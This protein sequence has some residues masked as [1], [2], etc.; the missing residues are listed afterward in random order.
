VADYRE[1]SQQYAQG[2]FKAV[3]LLNGGASVAIL[4]Q[5][6]ELGDLAQP[7]LVA[8]SF[9]A[10]GITLSALA[11]L[12]AFLS[13]RY[14]DKHEREG[15]SAH[16]DASNTWM[17]AAILAVLVSLALFVAGVVCLAAGFHSL[18]TT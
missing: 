14:V 13:T 9:W 6:P 3:A 1:I 11:W 12:A 18:H 4:T 8:S 7:V 2:G 10:A 5:L 17:Y 16:L 15:I